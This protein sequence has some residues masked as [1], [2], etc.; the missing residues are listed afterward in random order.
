VGWEMG[1]WDIV[2]NG[3]YRTASSISSVCREQEY[4]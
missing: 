4:M 1:G 2:Q 3:G